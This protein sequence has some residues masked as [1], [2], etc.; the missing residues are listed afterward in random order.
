MLHVLILAAGLGTRLRPLTD[1]IPKP[2]VPVVDDSI[3]AH[4][5]RFVRSLGESILHINAHYLASQIEKSA[6]ELGFFKVWHEEEL[7]GT[8]GPIRRLAS[9]LDV[10]ELLVLNG[11]CYCSMDLLSFLESA[12]NSSSPVALLG[13]DFSAVNTLLIR[14]SKLCGIANRFA[15]QKENARATFSGISWYSREALR[16]IADSERDIRDFWQRLVEKGAPPAVLPMNE[17]SIWIDMGTPAGLFSAVKARLAELGQ[18]NWIDSEIKS[19]YSDISFG[20]N[21]VVH[22]GAKLSSNIQLEN[23]LIFSSANLKTPGIY[24]NCIVGK[25]FFWSLE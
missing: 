12:R 25:N 14:D 21:V 11:D 2:L 18:K 20:N 17:N 10:D 15:T 24:K 16:E 3:L 4:Q 8:G 23:A 6:Q 7:L 19:K 5:V 13:R 9:N 22:T 1:S